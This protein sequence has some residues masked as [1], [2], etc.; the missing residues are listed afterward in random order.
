MLRCKLRASNLLAADN[1]PLPLSP[2]LQYHPDKNPDPK[3]HHYFSSYIAKVGWVL[4]A[5]AVWLCVWVGE[6]QLQ[7]AALWAGAGL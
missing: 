4:W 7:F 2:V 3:A 5:P 1:S 6:C